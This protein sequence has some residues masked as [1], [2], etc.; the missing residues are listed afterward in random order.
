[1]A[2]SWSGRRQLMYYGVG[3]VI[4]AVLF[5]VVWASF[6]NAAPTCFD[7]KQD[8]TELGVDCGGS[9]SLLCQD[10]ARQP[11]VQWARPFQTGAGIYTAAA[12]IQNNNVG[13]GAKNVQ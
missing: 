5:Y 8:G 9:C 3:L 4:L 13:A 2:L 7:N 1:M 12:Y 10:T 11:T 6:F